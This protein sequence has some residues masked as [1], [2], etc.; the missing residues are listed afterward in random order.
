T[1]LC[2]VG[3]HRGVV[4]EQRRGLRTR[5][6]TGAGDAA[7]KEAASSAASAERSTTTAPAERSTTAASSTTESGRRR[8]RGRALYCGGSDRAGHDDVRADGSERG[9]D[10]VLGV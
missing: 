8:C 1:E 6:R 2:E 10:T 7:G 3:D 9:Q 5:S 4:V